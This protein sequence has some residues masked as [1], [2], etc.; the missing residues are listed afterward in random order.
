MKGSA[1]SGEKRTTGRDEMGGFRQRRTL[2]V[3]CGAGLATVAAASALAG[4]RL[5]DATTASGR[6]VTAVRTASSPLQFVTQSTT[7]VDVPGAAAKITVP[8]STSGLILI[9]FTAST[10]CDLEQGGECLVRAEINGADASPG[11]VV[12]DSVPLVSSGTKPQAHA[13]DWSSGPLAPGT[14]TVQVQARTGS[15]QNGFFYLLRWHLV[16]ERV[17]V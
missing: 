2:L 8:A 14:Y 12:F 13:M 10:H 1:P 11:D 4:A 15:S 7:Y 3:V 5:G 16:V 6:S 9:Q 17:K